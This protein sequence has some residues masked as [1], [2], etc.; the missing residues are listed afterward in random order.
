MI[1]LEIAMLKPVRYVCKPLFLSKTGRHWLHSSLFSLILI[2]IASCS[3]D[4]GISGTSSGVEAKIAQ[5]SIIRKDG[6]AAAHARVR[7]IP[8]NYNPVSDTPLPHS[9]KSITNSDGEYELST[10]DTGFYNVQ[11]DLD[12]GTCALIGAVHINC[13]LTVIPAH[14]LSEPGTIKI[15][16]PDN[17]STNGYL[18][19]PGTDIFVNFKGNDDSAVIKSV[20]A[21]D[22][23]SIKYSNENMPEPSVLQSNVTVK[24][25]DTTVVALYNWSHSSSIYLNTTTS[26]A[27]ISDNVLN[28]PILARL[29]QGNFDFSQAQTHG[30]DIRFTKINGTTLPYEIELWDSTN[31]TATI[32]VMIDTIYGND[33][34]QSILM[35]W[36]NPSALS[37]SDSRK[38]F[39]ITAGFQGVWHLYNDE[40]NI[41]DATVNKYDGA[42][43]GNQARGSGV[44]GF[45]QYFDG[46]GDFT[47]M[48]N[49]CN[50]GIND[51]TFCGWIKKSA[52]GN[53]FTIASK[54]NG[55]SASSE[56]GWLI[57]INPDGA[58]FLFMATAAESWGNPGTFVL[59]SSK[60]IT[61]TAWHHIAVV[62][63]R[64]GEQNSRI[65][66]DGSDVSALPA[67][68]ITTISEITNTLPFRIGI[69][70]NGSNGWKGSLDEIS[71]SG[72]A[73]SS[74]YIKLTYENQKPGS[75]L[76]K[77]EYFDGAQ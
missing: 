48:G 73:R 1:R 50:P 29:D 3:S 36:G 24:A 72:K 51:F 43:K 53:R 71:F 5:G 8:V 59:A 65:Y 49:V 26:G 12:D 76:I 7:L 35:H 15:K 20:P 21:A 2:V 58:V 17:N 16:L 56:Y 25:G 19:L 30:E 63:D 46:S 41:P 34:T 31:A 45:G 62:A 67:S 69:D 37:E 18:Y 77:Y 28:V 55:G 32:W 38:V 23:P 10:S 42:R 44:I 70:A 40:D 74:N 27:P 9:T 52:S 54:S 47:E 60:Q 33:S 11:A 61:D 4:N 64:S 66:V 68:G 57:E 22:F 39:D 13:S 75:K 14:T 6:T